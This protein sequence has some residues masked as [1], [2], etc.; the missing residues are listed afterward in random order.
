MSW[1]NEEQKETGVE[2][3]GGTDTGVPKELQ[4]FA[5]VKGKNHF[6]SFKQHTGQLGVLVGIHGDPKVG[7]SH[8]A[9]SLLR[10]AD[11]YTTLDFMP[12]LL[13]LFYIDTHYGSR[14]TWWKYKKWINTICEPDDPNG[15]YFVMIDDEKKGKLLSGE[16]F[17]EKFDES[18][19]WAIDQMKKHGGGT[20]VI[21]N[22]TD[23][24]KALNMMVYKE[25]GLTDY[26]NLEP[27]RY[28]KRNRKLREAILRIKRY[29]NAIIIADDKE[30]WIDGRG[31]SSGIFDP[32]WYK[33]I[34]NWIDVKALMTK[35]GSTRTLEIEQAGYSLDADE[36]LGLKAI[37]PMLTNPDYE[38]LVMLLRDRIRTSNEQLE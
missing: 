2:A 16:P 27:K 24:Q 34:E 3:T 10:M 26:D 25:L 20:I 17:I 4:S 29:G 14:R 22:I 12:K 9:M 33:K 35:E 11:K 8:F 30:R 5:N 13:P 1:L 18:L 32:D 7:K 23:Y 37:D 15:W 38:S 31:T 19:Q 36:E 28:T 6:G 21:D